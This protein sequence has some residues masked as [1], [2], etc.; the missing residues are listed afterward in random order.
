MGTPKSA[1]TLQRM[2]QHSCTCATMNADD[3]SLFSTEVC[4]ECVDRVE[5]MALKREARKCP[6][7]PTPT[8]T[9]PLTKFVFLMVLLWYV[10][11]SQAVGNVTGA[12][13]RRRRQFCW[14]R[15]VR[16]E[17][18]RLVEDEQRRYV[19]HPGDR[20]RHRGEDMDGLSRSQPDHD[21]DHVHPFS[22][23]ST[24]RTPI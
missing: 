18:S 14:K 5:S 15:T 22:T 3:A 17:L 23:R 6:P 4:L 20:I 11:I 9:L 8:P 7:T 21:N 24:A 13:T 12:T 2:I 10:N 19:T 1:T 16:G